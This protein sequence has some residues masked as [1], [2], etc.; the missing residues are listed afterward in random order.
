MTASKAQ[1]AGGEPQ[2]VS[3]IIP[4]WNRSSLLPRALDS[5]LGQSVPA[6]EVIVV[7]DGSTDGTASMVAARYPQVRLLRTPHGGVS[8]A[9]NHGIRAV[10]GA[11]LAFLDSDDAWQPDKLASQLAAL[12]AQPEERV[13]HCDEIWIRNGR[14]VNP[15]RRHQKRGGWIFQHCLPLCAISPSAVMLHREV[16]DTVGLFDEALPACEDYDLWLRVTSRFPTLYIDRPLVIKHGGHADQLSRTEPALDRYRIRALAA[17][18]AAD[19]L[20]EP[21]RRAAARMLCEKIEVYVGGARKR[22]R[23]LEVAELEALRLRFGAASAP[24]LEAASTPDL[25]ERA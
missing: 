14:R 18:L 8:A 23:F 12:A 4:T 6:D 2:G 13:C 1:E 17:I 15:R 10:G 19:H 20:A 11:W 25:V 3:V 21:D 5:V 7:D 16:F 24:D 22:G 9:R